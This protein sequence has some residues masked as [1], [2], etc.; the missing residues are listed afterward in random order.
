MP[1]R[2]VLTEKDS[3]GYLVRRYKRVQRWRWWQRWLW[4]WWQ[5]DR[6]PKTRAAMQHCH[7]ECFFCKAGKIWQTVDISWVG[8]RVGGVQCAGK[9]SGLGGRDSVVASLRGV[10][11][12]IICTPSSSFA[13]LASL[14]KVLHPIICDN[15][16]S[17]YGKG[18]YS[19]YVLVFYF[20]TIASLIH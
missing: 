9:K 19:Y 7:L 1:E 14:S 4:K 10:S 2:T 8:W 20:F 17:A 13:H 18:N 11:Q 3:T 5:L 12:A 6:G 15:S 16:F